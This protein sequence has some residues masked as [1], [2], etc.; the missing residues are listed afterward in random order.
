MN[1]GLREARRFCDLLLRIPQLARLANQAIA[2]GL[3]LLY[4]A[5]LVSYLAKPGQRVLTSHSFSSGLHALLVAIAPVLVAQRDR[6]MTL[7][8]LIG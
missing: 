3:Q 6:S 2:P 4:A 8:C 1:A 7:D 5:D